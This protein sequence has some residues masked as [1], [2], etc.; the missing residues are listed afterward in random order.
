MQFYRALII[1]R[2]GNFTEEICIAAM[3]E[4]HPYTAKEISEVF[5]RCG[6][7]DKTIDVIYKAKFIRRTL[8]DTCELMGI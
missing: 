6:S 3:A 1:K 2:M 8:I 7:I 5:E 4:R